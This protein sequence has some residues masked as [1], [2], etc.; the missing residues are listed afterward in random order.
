MWWVTAI[1]CRESLGA[2]LGAAAGSIPDESRASRDDGRRLVA[3]VI[4]R[5]GDIDAAALKTMNR[6]AVALGLC[7]GPR[8]VAE[9]EEGVGWWFEWLEFLEMAADE[10][11]F[12]VW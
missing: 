8:S 5:C 10:R 2:W 4:C 3:D 11:G 12:E 1:E 6:C 9:I 7:E